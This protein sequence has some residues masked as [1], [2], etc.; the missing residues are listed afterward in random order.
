MGQELELELFQA[1]QGKDV[2]ALRDLVAP[3]GRKISDA[4]LALA[5]LNGG[6]ETLRE[7][8]SRLPDYPEIQAALS[9][10]DRACASLA[11]E[12]VRCSFDLGELRGYH[13]HT[14]IV[15]AAYADGYADAIGRGGRYDE[16]GR[17]F[18]RARPATGFT[19]DLRDIAGMMERPPRGFGILA[20]H[21][22]DAALRET[23]GRLRA[24][25]E[26][27]IVDLPGH[28]V[29]RSE[30]RTDRELRLVDGRWQVVPRTLPN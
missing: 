2:P 7:A 8:R 6:A 16:I 19:L 17:A 4:L 11:P 10:L 3:L 9:D 25:G 30:L 1:L 22:S 26:I 13:Y 23:M 18:G 29:V 24:E 21:S 14:G 5:E 27:V 12:S 20:P 15:F 28:E